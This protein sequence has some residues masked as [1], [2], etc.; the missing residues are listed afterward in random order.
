MQT[1]L[2]EEQMKHIATMITGGIEDVTVVIAPERK[3][4]NQKGE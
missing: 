4:N 1:I 2:S 3:I